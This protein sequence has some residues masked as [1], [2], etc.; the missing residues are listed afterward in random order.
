MDFQFNQTLRFYTDDEL[1]AE[2]SRR[3]DVR[4]HEE[5]VEELATHMLRNPSEV[6]VEQHSYSVE[7]D[8]MTYTIEFRK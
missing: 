4:N 3:D 2:L 6:S 8:K 7:S 1:I 5:V